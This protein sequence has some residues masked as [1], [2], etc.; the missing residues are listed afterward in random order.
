MRPSSRGRT[1]DASTAAAPEPEVDLRGLRADEAERSLVG[2][3]DR[4]AVADLREVRVIH[5][6]GTGAL[7]KRVGEV[8]ERD[9]RVE[10]FRAGGV[11]EGGFGVTVA[12]MR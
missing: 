9:E 6:K 2:A 4:A 8:L 3:L 1:G 10:R 5:G 11:G 12:R 7:R